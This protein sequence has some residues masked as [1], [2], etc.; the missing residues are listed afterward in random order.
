MKGA[1]SKQLPRPENNRDGS[2][3]SIKPAR[4][5]AGLGPGSVLRS[6]RGSDAAPE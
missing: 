1:E 2:A 4:L 6:M 3:T 5:A